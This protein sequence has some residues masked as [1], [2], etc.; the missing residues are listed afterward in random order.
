MTT[1]KFYD[2]H[3]DQL[4]KDHWAAFEDVMCGHCET[5]LHSRTNEQM[6]PWCETIMP[7]AQGTE[8]CIPCYDK[9]FKIY[10]KSME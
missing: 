8:L 1:V 3:D 10:R 2:K 6:R 4:P 9:W 7:G 5:Y